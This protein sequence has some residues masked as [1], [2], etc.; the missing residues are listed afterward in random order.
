MRALLAA[1]LALVWLL[2]AP[3][4]AEELIVSLSQEEVAISSNFSGASI[5]LFGAIER[6]GRTVSRPEGY[7]TVVVL[8]GPDEDVVTRRKERTFGI[9]IN[10]T[11]RE[12]QDVPS[13]Y[14]VLSNR[15]LEAIAPQ[16]LLRRMELG[17]DYI[18]LT[19]AQD[20]TR[21]EQPSGSAYADAF[22]RLKQDRA[23]Y[24]ARPDAVEFVGGP[25]F[26]ANV[27]L[28]ATVPDGRYTAEVYLF[29][30]GELL[31]TASADVEINKAGFEQLIYELAN[32]QPLLYGLLAVL[33]A[34][35]I[36]WLA[37]VLFR[38]E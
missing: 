28:P 34:L 33:T 7:D 16:D 22:R 29:S 12:Y 11:A 18:G 8:R 38:R 3:A 1:G 25:L 30:S 4:R 14:A 19:T 36:G 35:F 37:S 15:A 24:D 32:E 6:D 26:R 13:F 9:W 17:L 2:A 27:A 10:R 5:V 23:L 31:A 21:E 20:A